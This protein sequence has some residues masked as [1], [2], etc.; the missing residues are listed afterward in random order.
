MFIFA[1]GLHKEEGMKIK[2]SLIERLSSFCVIYRLQTDK[3]F[4]SYRQIPKDLPKTNP[5]LFSFLMIFDTLKLNIFFD[6]EH[7]RKL[8]KNLPCFQYAVNAWNIVLETDAN[9]TVLNGNKSVEMQVNAAIWKHKPPTDCDIIWSKFPD[10]TKLKEKDF[11]V[12]YVSEIEDFKNRTVDELERII[13]LLVQ[14]GDVDKVAKKKRQLLSDIFG[15]EI[16]NNSLSF[17]YL[18]DKTNNKYYGIGA[19]FTLK[20]NYFNCCP[21]ADT[22]LITKDYFLSKGFV[23]EN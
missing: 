12:G 14:K 4:M 16:V 10:D 9:G 23:F 18:E 20:G 7:E 22:D 5:L 21:I 19:T 1:L 2:K 15:W 17:A 6:G 3:C 11:E 8:D 13:T